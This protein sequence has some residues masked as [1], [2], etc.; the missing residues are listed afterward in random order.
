[1]SQG[2]A[3]EG[4]RLVKEY[5]PRAYADGTDI[6]ARAHM[7]SAAIWVRRLPKRAWRNPRLVAP[8]WC[9]L[10]THHGTTNAVCMPAVLQFNQARNYG[11]YGRSGQYLGVLRRV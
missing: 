2:M 10:H 7:M 11:C 8:D 4:M 3:L 6:E 5:L 9:D 1:M